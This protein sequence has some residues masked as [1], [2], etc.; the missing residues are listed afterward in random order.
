[1]FASLEKALAIYGAGKGGERPVQDKQQL[2][3]DLRTAVA[4]ATGYCAAH[5]VKLEEIEAQAAGSLERPQRIEDATNALISPDP[6][7]RDFFGHERLVGTLYRAVKPDP[8]ALQYA[9]RAACLATLGEV[10]RTR[11]NPN[12][13]DIADVLRSIAGM[14]DESIAGHE[15]REG[16][17][18]ALDLSKID[19]EALAGRFGAADKSKHRNTD[20]EVLKAAI[21]ARLERMIRAN[22]TRADFAE[23]FE[24]LIDSN[25][26]SRI[27]SLF[28]ELLALSRSLDDEQQRHVREV[29]SEEELVIFDILTRPA[30]EL[31]AEER[32]EVKKVA[33]EL[34][35]R[36]KELLVLDWR[37]KAGARAQLQLAIQDTLDTG[38]PRAYTPELYRQKCAA[39]FEHV[40]ESYPERRAGA[41]A[42]AT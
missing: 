19:F 35:A 1:M 12:P 18:P 13:P 40:Y 27:E 31:T 4:A 7:R 10:I 34:L 36:L 29:I 24:A 41:Y 30:P 21:R 33:R 16:G 17:P 14:L 15:I 39:V 23:K 26:G 28:A 20:L 37:K 8:A 11:L 6:L 25:A 32:A 42:G 3:E 9:G 38:L 5:G 22:R 2:V